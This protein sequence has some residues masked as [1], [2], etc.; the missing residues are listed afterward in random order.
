MGKWKGMMI[1]GFL[2]MPVTITYG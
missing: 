2:E 1:S